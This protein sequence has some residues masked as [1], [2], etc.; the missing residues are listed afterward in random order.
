MLSLLATD[1]TI[2]DAKAADVPTLAAM[3]AAIDQLIPEPP[4]GGDRTSRK[5]H[6]AL[7]I[8]TNAISSPTAF[9]LA[10]NYK[11]RPIGTISGHIYQQP[12]LQLSSIGVIYSLW[13]DERFRCRGVGLALLETLERKMVLSGAQAFQVGWGFHNHSA[14]RWWQKRGYSPYET[15]ASKSAPLS[16]TTTNGSNNHV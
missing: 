3:W 11:Q 14:A 7:E 5:H 1:I 4:F 12:V 9:A 8:L 10:A 16:K 6:R 15:I 2:E 13:V